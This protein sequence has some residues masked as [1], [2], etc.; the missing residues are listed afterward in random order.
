[1]QRGGHLVT[2]ALLLEAAVIAGNPP[3][4]YQPYRPP[5]N[6]P[7]QTG[8]PPAAE[9]AVRSYP[10]SWYYDPYTQGVAGLPQREGD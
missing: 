4:P 1:M 9:S 7:Q 5:A 6:L 8:Q 2:L 10:P 3:P